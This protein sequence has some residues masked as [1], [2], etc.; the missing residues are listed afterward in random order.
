MRF[1]RCTFALASLAALFSCTDVLAQGWGDLKGQVVWTGA[2]PKKETLDINKDQGH[3]L[4]KGA[5]V[6]DALL[7]DDKTKGIKYV[8]VW[9]GPAEPGGKLALNPALP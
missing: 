1:F 8:I 2:V 3:C 4:S 7:I 6:N 9:L 5:I